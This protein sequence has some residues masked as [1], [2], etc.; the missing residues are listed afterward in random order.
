MTPTNVRG[1]RLLLVASCCFVA[2][3]LLRRYGHHAPVVLAVIV[4]GVILLRATYKSQLVKNPLGDHRDY[5]VRPAVMAAVKGLGAWAAGMLWAVLVT[6]AVRYKYL[7]DNELTGIG[8]LLVPLALLLGLG[9]YY[10]LKAIRRAQFGGE[11][12]SQ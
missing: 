9:A 12:N 11:K 8:L 7:P 2:V 6:L 5:S 10:I 4:G 1:A 3:Y